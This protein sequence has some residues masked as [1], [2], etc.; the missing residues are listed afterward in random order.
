MTW[1]IGS[2]CIWIW[3]CTCRY[4]IFI[5]WKAFH[6]QLQPKHGHTRKFGKSR[7]LPLF[8]NKHQN[9][10]NLIYILSFLCFPFLYFCVGIIRNV[11][12]NCVF[13]DVL[14]TM[15]YFL[16]AI[17]SYS[18]QGSF[19]SRFNSHSFL[20]MVANFYFVVHRSIHKK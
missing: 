19:G 13:V 6:L 2:Q 8:C 7:I 18:G 17:C 11:H 10:L 9:F 1:E 15:L 16:Q 3:L 12:W 4:R 20:S 5:H 14:L